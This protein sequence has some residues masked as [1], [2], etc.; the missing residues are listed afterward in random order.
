MQIWR[1]D[2]QEQNE[3][4]NSNVRPELCQKAGGGESFCQSVS[5][6]QSQQQQLVGSKVQSAFA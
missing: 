4:N 1:I 2:K 6:Q 3:S 5:G